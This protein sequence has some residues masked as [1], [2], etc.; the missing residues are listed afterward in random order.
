MTMITEAR[1]DYCS[2][3]SPDLTVTDCPACAEPVGLVQFDDAQPTAAEL[4]VLQETLSRAYLRRM[5]VAHGYTS[6][7]PDVLADELEDLAAD[8][9][10]E[11]YSRWLCPVGA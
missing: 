4:L 9:A 2:W 11:R 10:F 6:W 7:P 1:C 8:I 5:D 3:R